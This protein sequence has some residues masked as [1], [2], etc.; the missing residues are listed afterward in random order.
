M[1]KRYIPGYASANYF[2][3]NQPRI[4]EGTISKKSGL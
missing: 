2:S 1:R 4:I 3:E